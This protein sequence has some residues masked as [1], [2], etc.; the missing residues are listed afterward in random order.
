MQ[1]DDFYF[2]TLDAVGISFLKSGRFA[3]E[4]LTKLKIIKSLQKSASDSVFFNFVRMSLAKRPLLRKLML[5]ASRV[6]K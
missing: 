3:K 6:Q 2:W 1:N 4:I 5:T